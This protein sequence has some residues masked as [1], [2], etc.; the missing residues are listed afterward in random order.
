MGREREQLL[1]C[2][3]VYVSGRLTGVSGGAIHA[4]KEERNMVKAVMVMGQSVNNSMRC[5]VVNER[6]SFTVCIISN[7]VCGG[8]EGDQGLAGRDSG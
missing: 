5:I 7:Q 6:K 3:A 4:D 2:R 1:L 8:H